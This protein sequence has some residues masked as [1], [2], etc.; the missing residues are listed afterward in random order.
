MMRSPSRTSKESKAKT[1]ESTIKKE[2]SENV[3]SDEIQDFDDD[4]FSPNEDRHY[5]LFLAG[6]VTNRV[7]KLLPANKPREE[8]NEVI[9][10]TVT[11]DAGIS[12][13]VDDFA[14]NEYYDK[15]SYAVIPVYVR[16]YHKKN[17]D[18]AYTLSVKKGRIIT[19]GEEF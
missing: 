5:G 13:Y 15:N 1:T 8:Q 9:T 3:H 4:D 2:S 10:Y 14:P 17:G 12:H 18:L 6:I 16:P 11:D 19:K 7:R